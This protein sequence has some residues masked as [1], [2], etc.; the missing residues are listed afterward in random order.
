MS[1]LRRVYRNNILLIIVAAILINTSV[2]LLT[3]AAGS[4][5]YITLTDGQ[6]Q[7]YINSY[8][9]FLSSTLENGVTMSLMP[10]YKHGFPKESLTRSMN[11]YQK[12]EGI[13][14]KYDDNVGITLLLQYQLSDLLILAFIIIITTLLLL[15]RKKGLVFM[16]RSSENGRGRLYLRRVGILALSSILGVLVINLGIIIALYADFGVN[17]LS[18]PIQSLPEFMK[19]PYDLSIWQYIV[20]S[21]FYKAFYV[22]MVAMIFFLLISLLGSTTSYVVMGGLGVIQLLIYF[23]IDP[24]SSLNICRYLGPITLLNFQEFFNSCRYINLFGHAVAAI[25]LL[26]VFLFIVS[27]VLIITGYF[28]HEKVYVKNLNPL[29]LFHERLSRI[30]EQFHFQRSLLGWEAY[31]I[32]IKQGGIVFILLAFLLS[33]YFNTRYSYNYPGDPYEREWYIHYEGE[34]TDELY[35]RASNRLNSLSDY[36]S[37]T[38]KKIKELEDKRA[39]GEKIN[40]NNIDSLKANL[41][42][43]KKHQNTLIPIVKIIES[44]LEY[45]D[46]SGVRVWLVKPYA[47]ELL[48]QK[49]TN[50][51]RRSFLFILL[52]IIGTFSGIY[53][54]DS[55]NNM[56]FSIRSSYRGRF[57]IHAAKV[58][59]ILLISII[60]TLSIHLPQFVLIGKMLGYN[61]LSVPVQSLLFLRDFELNISIRGYLIIFYCVNVL[62]TF[63]ISLVCALVSRLSK[64]T[65]TSA[66]ICALFIGIITLLI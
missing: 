17:N 16:I 38:E 8:P 66:G 5:R 43:A 27:S 39:S 45:Y 41:D 32:L 21:F 4:N 28:V 49:D 50:T 42:V 63:V 31:K 64:D 65:L 60:L 40:P 20:T 46:K 29:K 48:L 2:F 36:I 3:C 34:I 30:I 15:E 19:C 11:A 58:I 9:D 6:L 52:G 14:P 61:N 23:F 47:Y 22:F 57:G 7:E 44:G 33:L 37:N 54:Y 12:L 59:L 56:V 53:A 55:Q 18:R 26:F 13:L 24:V 51:T 62:I 1:E 35:N 25:N 10:M